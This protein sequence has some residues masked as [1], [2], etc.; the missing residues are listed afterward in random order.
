M[1]FA[2]KRNNPDLMKL[3]IHYKSDVNARDLNGR[4]PLFY[5][6]MMNNVKAVA[7]L[8][9]NMG[10][11]FAMDKDGTKLDEVTGHPDI[12]KMIGKG[13]SVSAITHYT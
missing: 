2:A 8:L 11:A 7:I 10:N 4:T 9:A 6:A 3:L 1:H 12:L 5:A 13:K